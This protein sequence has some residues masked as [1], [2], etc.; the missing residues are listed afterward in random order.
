M[1]AAIRARAKEIF[2]DA[3]AMAPAERAAFLDQACEGD[4][5]LRA[6]V[7][8]LLAAMQSA[9]DFLAEPT[10]DGDAP[11]LGAGAVGP[12][13]VIGRYRLLRALGEG[14]FGV[15]YLAEQLRPVTRRVALKILKIGMDTRRVVARFE[16]ERQ[17]L[18]LMDHPCIASVLD[19]GATESGRPYFVMEY[20]QGEPI[21]TYCIRKRLGVEDRLRLFERVCLAVQHAH[22]KGVIHRDLKPSNVLVTQVD[23]EATP[24]VIDFGVAKAI[25]GRLS[26]QTIVTEERSLIG[27]PA[28]MSPEQASMSPGSVDTRS[29]VYSLGVLL[30]EMLAASPPFDQQRLRNASYSEFQRILAEEEPPRPSTRMGERGGAGADAAASHEARRMRQRVRGELDWIVM[31]ALEKDRTRRYQSAGSLAAEI[32]RFLEGDPVEAGPPTARYRAWKYARRHRVAVGAS[33]VVAAALLIGAVA[34]GAG[35][36]EA[37]R[38]NRELDDALHVARIERDRAVE[39]ERQAGE[40]AERARRQA[41]IAS[42]VNEFLNDDLLGAVSPDEQGRDVTMRAA[43]DAAI[44]RLDEAAAP[45]GALAETPEV[46]CALRTTIGATLRSL[47]DYEAAAPHLVRGHELASSIYGADSVTA[48]R[49]LV[50]LAQLRR[51]EGRHEEALAM[52]EQALAAEEAR[53]SP[54]PDELTTARSNIAVV[55]FD[56]GRFDEAVSMME[57]VLAART[58]RQGADHPDTLSTQNNLAMALM[59]RGRLDESAA[60]LEQAVEG[61]RRTLG[62]EHPRTLVS[63]NNLGQV[64]RRLGRIEEAAAIYEESLAGKRVAFGPDHPETLTTTN[65][66]ALALLDLKRYDEAES[67][68]EELLSTQRRVLG[69]THWQTCSTMINLA[70]VYK[71]REQ[72]DR[73]EPLNREAVAGGRVG[74][75]A[76]HWMLGVFIGHL[77]VT[78]VELERYEEAEATL[79]EAHAMLLEAM[80]PDHA[81]TVA[82]AEQLATLYRRWGHDEDAAEWAKRAGGAPDTP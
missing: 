74:L 37:R 49:A 72:W 55:L 27:T 12:G 51:L 17:A 34:A 33:A 57:Q 31:R 15:V 36:V 8:G 62:A 43:L 75:P 48:M 18:A 30:Y 65:N 38:A 28:Y 82:Q 70:R 47:G 71:A 76:G 13:E 54:D 77:G 20:V 66:L 5:R 63:M 4:A 41:A 44:A 56:L 22:Q 3:L 35:L 24:K 60:M 11:A 29:D 14:G 53:P 23:G 50:E 1:S 79:L 59:N 45:G 10:V 81:R 46:E 21:T 7:D 52:F 32:R 67:M 25:E 69:D 26:D 64:Y 68:L 40:E 58:A 19:A 16:A 42:A 6:V 61:R 78:L 80:G 73:A 39:A 2:A 9:S